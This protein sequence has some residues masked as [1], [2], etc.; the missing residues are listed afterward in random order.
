MLFHTHTHHLFL[1]LHLSL[2]LTPQAIPSTA[3]RTFTGISLSKGLMIVFRP[4]YRMWPLTVRAFL[5]PLLVLYYWPLIMI[6]ATV[7]TKG[8]PLTSEKVLKGVEKVR[9]ESAI[10]LGKR[11]A[12]FSPSPSISSPRLYSPLRSSWST[13]NS[14]PS[15]SRTSSGWRYRTCPRWT[16]LSASPG[17]RRRGRLRWRSLRSPS[18]RYPR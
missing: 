15:P 1:S 17:T 2:S 9:E 5:Q 3:L 13:R 16:S 8:Y 10:V 18:R 14:F 6:R 7:M 4:F 12:L 11:G